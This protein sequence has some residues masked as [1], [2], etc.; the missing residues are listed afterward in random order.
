MAGKSNKL[1]LIVV[2]VVA[3]VIICIA[4]GFI[5]LSSDDD[6]DEAEENTY[7]FYIG[8]GHYASSTIQNGWISAEGDNALDGLYNA[9]DEND[10]DYY[11]N[12]G[13]ITSINNVEPVWDDNSAEG[14]GNWMW[15]ADGFDDSAEGWEWMQT[16]IS[17]TT[18]GK[19]YYIFVIEYDT[20]TYD[21]QYDPHTVSGWKN[22]G[23]FA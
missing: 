14:W 19:A 16:A 22:G 3:V 8:Y 6:S 21:P 2:A 23:P 4:A 5:V 15:T 18:T 9:L 11:I 17:E 20:E 1:L 12:N 10:I 7:W 13:W